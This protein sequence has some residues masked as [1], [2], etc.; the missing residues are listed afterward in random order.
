MSASFVTARLASLPVLVGGTVGQGY[1]RG[2]GGAQD[3]EARLLRMAGLVSSPSRCSDDALDDVGAAFV[4]PRAPCETNDAY[5]A[6]LTSPTA[7]PWPRWETAPTRAGLAL[8]FGPYNNGGVGQGTIY[9]DGDTAWV[10][11]AHPGLVWGL[12]DLALNGDT[13]WDLSGDYDDGGLWDLFYD[14]SL[15]PALGFGVTDLDWMRRE[16]RRLKGAGAYP[17]FVFVG[18]TADATSG[19]GPFWDSLGAAW[20]VVAGEVWDDLT[21]YPGTGGGVF[22]LLPL[23]HIWEEDELFFGGGPGCWDSGDGATWDDFYPPS[24]GW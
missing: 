7:G 14:G 4:M 6:R 22:T 9:S 12:W 8:T 16:F 21:M 5:R 1:A 20:D 23:G 18:V 3:D 11:G 24:G 15:P 10:T 2:L 19:E 13:A 17:A